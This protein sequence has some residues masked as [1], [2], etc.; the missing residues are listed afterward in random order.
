MHPKPMPIRN[1]LLEFRIVFPK[2]LR[3]AFF[4]RKSRLPGTP[5][6]HAKKVVGRREGEEEGEERIIDPA[7]D[8]IHYFSAGFILLVMPVFLQL[9]VKRKPSGGERGIRTPGGV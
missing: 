6:P 8:S 7:N 9:N 3:E 1:R 5:S 4:P 2:S